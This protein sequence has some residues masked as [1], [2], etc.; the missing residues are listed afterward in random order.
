[1]NPTK[2]IL[3]LSLLLILTAKGQSQS[4]YRGCYGFDCKEKKW[5]AALFAGFSLLGPGLGI[6]EQMISSGLGDVRPAFEDWFG[7]EKEVDYPKGRTGLVLNLEVMY[8]LSKSSGLQFTVGEHLRSSVEGYDR[9]GFGNYLSISN[10]VWSSSLDYVLKIRN[11]KDAL[12]I[13]PEFALLKTTADNPS[14]YHPV[15]KSA[16][17]FKAGVNIGY[18]LTLVQKKSWF[19]SLKAKYTWLPDAEIGPYTVTHERGIIAEDIETFTSTFDKTVVNLSTI[20]IGVSTG[21]KF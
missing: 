10:D 12:R 19:L 7:T 6:K 2:I 9:I 14:I 15:I 13:G 8:M 21:F 17:S 4:T 3:I 20:N 11:R 1:M 18:S 16:S 5:S